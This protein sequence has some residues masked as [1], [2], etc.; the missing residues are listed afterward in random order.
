MRRV[1]ILGA[2]QTRFEACKASLAYNELVYGVVREVLDRTGVPM[3]EIESMVTAS[4][5]AYDGKT[6]SGMAI[7]EVVGAYL[8]SEAKV[9]ADGLQAL[10]YGVARILSGE[11]DLTLVVAHCKE[12]E[13]DPAAITGLMFDPFV[14]RPLHLDELTA[15]ALQARRYCRKKGLAPEDVALVSVKAHRQALKNPYAQR[16]GM[17]SVS[18]V[19][20]SPLLADPI[21]E[22]EAAPRSDGACALLLASEARARAHTD[23]PVF[24]IG[25]GNCTDAYWTERDLAEARALQEAARRAYAMAGIREPA[26]EIHVA[27]ISARYAHEELMAIEALGLHPNLVELIAQERAACINPSGGPLCGNPPTVSGL[28][29][30]IEAYAQLS[31]EAGARQIEGARTA[32]AHGAGGIC[33][34]NQTVVILQ[35]E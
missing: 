4:Q 1:A 9:A 2:A 13:G 8:K 11:F 32:L 12:S 16:A 17:F 18:D 29:R 21:H 31:G 10:L 22:L 19:L 34:Q 5:D 30:A 35:R 24:I 14:Q 3:R 27:E 25:I 26:R 20:A 33:G 15:A 7:N 6:I 23:R 28:L